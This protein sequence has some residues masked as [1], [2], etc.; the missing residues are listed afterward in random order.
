MAAPDIPARFGHRALWAVF[1]VVVAAVAPHG[2][3][4]PPTP[5]A[6]A[7]ADPF[8]NF[9][10]RDAKT[11]PRLADVPGLAAYMDA[12]GKSPATSGD[13]YAAAQA[14]V[15]A[16]R[17]TLPGV[18]VQEG[19]L[20]GAEVVSAMP[21]A[22]FL[23]GPGGDRVA[24]LR[25]FLDGH[26]AAYGL[27]ASQVDEL[28]VVADRMNPAG[29][30]AWVELEQRIN[31]IRVFQG[32]LR[33]AFTPN[34]E[35]ARISGRLATGAGAGLPTAPGPVGGRRRWR[36]PRPPSACR[37]RRTRC[38]SANADD[39]R[40]VFEPGAMAD[41]AA[42]VARVFSARLRRGPPG[43]GH[44]SVRRS[45]QVP[46]RPGRR[47]RH[48]DLPQEPH[49]LPD[50]AGHLQRL[51]Q[52]QPGSGV[53]FAGLAGLELRRRRWSSRQSV[54]LDRQRAAVRVQQPRLDHRWRQRRATATPTA[55]T[56]KPASIAWR[57]MAS[58]RWCPARTGRFSFSYNPGP[59]AP[60]PGEAP[61]TSAFQNGE[62][63]NVFYWVNRFHDETVSASVSPRHSATTSTTTSA[64]AA[65]GGDRISAEAQDPHHR[66]R[67]LRDR[68]DGTRGRLQVGLWTAPPPDYGG[69]L[70]A[71][72]VAP[73]TD[74]RPVRAGC[75]T[76]VPGSTATWP[77]ALGEGWSD[78]VRPVAARRVDRGRQRPL[79]DRR[80]V[81]R[82]VHG[83]TYE[84][85]YYGIRRFPYAVLNAMGPNGRPHNPLTFA[86]IDTTQADLTDGAFP[87]NTSFGSLVRDSVTRGRP[88]LGRDAAGDSRARFI[89]R[90]G[91]AEGNRRIL[92]LVIDGMKGDRV[93]PTFLDARDSIL[94]AAAG[95]RDAGRRHRHLGGLRRARP[96]VS[97]RDHS[98][99]QQR[100]DPRRRKLPDAGR[101]AGDLQGQR[102][103][104]PGGQRRHHDTDVHGVAR[105]PEF[106]PVHRGLSDG[107]RDGDLERGRTRSQRRQGRSR[108]RPARPATTSGAASPYPATL[109]VTGL[110]GVITKVAIRLDGLTHTQTVDLDM[111]LVAPGGQRAMFMSEVGAGDVANLTATFEDGAL[112]PPATRL[113]SG[114]FA[115]TNGALAR[116]DGLAGATRP[117]HH[118]ALG[119]RRRE[120]ERHMA[121]LHHGRRRW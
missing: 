18:Q 67:Q 4:Q 69:G 8:P 28:V 117:V 82:G 20:G 103:R 74:A 83:R 107:Q 44:R 6:M 60:P 109:D 55:T 13:T 71:D 88:D 110:T 9:D 45:A 34:G 118:R 62:V 21:G 113:V 64:A 94:A 36:S 30:M 48:G 33:G 72:V 84:N 31:G 58:M 78:F 99:R 3:T 97:C 51:H 95:R 17:R 39:G 16:L 90:L 63:T 93:N 112:P 38:R 24:T 81:D 27:V 121:P 120:S 56:S 76:T 26:Q 25:G 77:A 14:G 85:Y 106:R 23:T 52:R 7:V 79:H 61:S 35:L 91:F 47:D 41:A 11:D 98:Q 102:R 86:D 22:A 80:L 29:N 10:I 70:D 96:G 65:L 40:V 114:T 101:S 115:P 37:P 111:L 50:G 43:V 75:T 105:Q 49:V 1:G 42:G 116:P 54:T 59:G 104:G 2:G 73:R 92:Q 46:H 119:V 89:T 66:Q 12:V 19:L 87:P 15:T 100:L 108:C 32:Q 57:P 53:A 68:S 5:A